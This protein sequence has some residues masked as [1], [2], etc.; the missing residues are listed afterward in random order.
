[1]SQLSLSFSS[2]DASSL[3]VREVVGTYRPA[4][5]AEVL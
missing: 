1:M 4:E 3:L 2:S 5:P